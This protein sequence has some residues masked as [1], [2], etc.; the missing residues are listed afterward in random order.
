[1]LGS[2]KKVIIN[3]DDTILIE[4]AGD[5]KQIQERVELLKESVSSTTSSY[6]KDKFQERLAKLTGGVAVFKVGG[7]SETEVNELKDRINDAICATKAAAEQ[8]IVPGGGSA[9]LF[10][11]KHIKNLEG[12]N[13]DQN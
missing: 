2:C 3:K 9:L 8:G 13:F 6:D 12:E 11:V 1:M 5:K 7:V 10:A 4:G